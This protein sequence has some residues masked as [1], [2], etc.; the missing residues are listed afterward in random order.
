MLF[1]LTIQAAHSLS[2]LMSPNNNVSLCLSVHLSVP[3]LNP[4]HCSHQW[5]A[6][7]SQGLLHKTQAVVQTEDKVLLHSKQ[8]QHLHHVAM[9]SGASP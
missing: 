8:L 2:C 9:W 1:V 7:A 3:L 5:P 4:S 6:C